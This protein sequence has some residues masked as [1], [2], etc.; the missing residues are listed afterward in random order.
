M[1]YRS[2]KVWWGALVFGTPV[3]AGVIGGVVLTLFTSANPA[4]ES[5]RAPLA[6]AGAMMIVVPAILLW[7]YFSAAYE[8]TSEELIV[9]FGPIRMRY[10]LASIVEAIPTLVPLG[11]AWS[12]ATSW[13]MVYIKFRGPAG[14]AAG[15]PLAI[16]PANKAEFLRELAERVPGLVGPVE[17]GRAHPTRLEP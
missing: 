8:I 16:S 3:L 4:P 14:R 7:S 9:R 11:P 2:K 17:S 1:V 6:I 12:L 10:R 5:V 15:L 13:D